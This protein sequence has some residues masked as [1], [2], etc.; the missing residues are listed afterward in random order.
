LFRGVNQISLDGKGR[1]AMPTKYRKEILE[2]CHGQLVITVDRDMCLLIYPLEQWEVIEK[3][4]AK[5][6]SL[7]KAAR[8]LQR[9]LIGHA[10]EVDMDAHGRILVPL[11]LREFANFEKRVVLIGQGH[12]FELWDAQRWEVER[13]SWL[14][15]DDEALPIEMESISL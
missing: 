9:L 10:T 1:M 13:Q 14:A 12:K 3:K 2:C 4:L 11:P 15:A 5:L 7:N 8:R 6:P